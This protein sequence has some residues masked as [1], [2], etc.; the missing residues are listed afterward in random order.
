ML[1]SQQ[2]GLLEASAGG[3]GRRVN[4]GAF[5]GTRGGGGPCV[6]QPPRGTYL[7]HF[8]APHRATDVNDKEDVFGDRVQVVGSK[9]VDEIS[10]KYLKNRT[11]LWDKRSATCGMQED[12]AW[13]PGA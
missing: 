11:S 3:G 13:D 1:L 12:G 5:G 6:P 9:K 4:E 10:I 2:P 7:F 8:Y